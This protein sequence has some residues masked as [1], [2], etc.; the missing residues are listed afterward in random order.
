M[1]NINERQISFRSAAGNFST[2]K[3]Y[4]DGRIV[5]RIPFVDS[6]DV[7]PSSAQFSLIPST[8][9]EGTISVGTSTTNSGGYIAAELA[10]AVG[11]AATT[12]ISDSLGNIL[13]M[14]AIRDAST[15]DEIQEGVGDTARTIFGLI[16]CSNAVADGTSIGGVGSENLQISFVYYAEDGTITLATAL[17]RTIEFQSNKVITR[18]NYPTIALE[19]GANSL[20]PDI[21]ERDIEPTQRSFIVTTGYAAN[22]V[23][24]LATGDGASTGRS[25]TS[26]DTLTLQATEGAFNTDNTTK[27]RLNGIQQRKGSGNDVVWD[28]TT[29]LH[30]TTALDVGDYIEVE[31]VVE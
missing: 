14:V 13:N 31:R 7:S 10:G 8:I 2:L 4:L 17:T 30:F 15:H 26:G 21:L 27:I 29:T 23:I 5:K 28:S 18:R 3:D 6:Q 12:T 11:T 16:Q 20:T 24:T 22:E 1:S 19:D 25:T 9:L